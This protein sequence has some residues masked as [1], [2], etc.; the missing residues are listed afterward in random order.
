MAQL[1][2]LEK[3]PTLVA[4]DKV[5]EDYENSKPSRT[6]LGMSSIGRSCSRELWYSFRWCDDVVFDSGT[7]KRFLDGHHGEDVQAKRLQ[8]VSGVDLKTIDYRT[9]KQFGFIDIGGHF[10]GHMDGI[11]KGILQASKTPHVWEHK[12]VNESKF[13]KLDKLRQDYGEKGALEKWDYTY[14]SQAVLYMS[15][16]GLTRHYLTCSTPGGR[17]TTSVRTEP[18]G[19]AV[20]RLK[21]KAHQIIASTFPPPRINDSPSWYECIYCNYEGICHG[22][23]APKVSCRTCVHLTPLLDTM[24][25]NWKC[26]RFGIL[27]D[28]E[29][30][31]VGCRD[32]VFIPPLLHW[33]TAIDA[34]DTW[35]KYEYK[36]KTFTNSGDRTLGFS[37]DEIRNAEPGILIDSTFAELRNAFDGTI[38]GK[39]E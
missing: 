17:A 14:Y 15:Y 23:K 30:Q 32:H 38:T 9:G 11:I 36:G 27:V 28:T 6:Y 22:N 5:L 39:G 7:H 2:N 4:A 1:P 29:H 18:D 35:V 37:S 12:Q 34:D 31:R 26:E 16:S 25:G 13:K 24:A 8:M 20:E 19:Q 21:E 10:R 3:D 33:A